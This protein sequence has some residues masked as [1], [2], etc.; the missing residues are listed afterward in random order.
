MRASLTAQNVLWLLTIWSFIYVYQ[1]WAQTFHPSLVLSSRAMSSQTSS[2]SIFSRAQTLEVKEDQVMFH[3]YRN[4]RSRKDYRKPSTK[5]M[6]S[7]FNE[8]QR[9]GNIRTRTSAAN[10]TDVVRSFSGTSS[11]S[12]KTSRTITEF[13]IPYLP[14]HERLK[15]AEIRFLREPKAKP[16]LQQIKIRINIKKGSKALKKIVIRERPQT[17]KE[18]D[19]IDVTNFISPWINS[20]HGNFSLAIRI[21]G[22]QVSQTKNSS[23]NLAQSLIVLYLQDGEFLANM[24]SSFTDSA[25]TARRLSRRKRSSSS[26]LGGNLSSTIRNKRDRNLKKWNRAGK[27]VNCQLHNFEVDFNTIGWGQWIIHPK[28]YNA[29]FCFGVCPSPVDSKYKP[30]NHAMLQT[31]MRLKRPNVAPAPCCVPTRLNPLSM[32]YYEFNELV[33]RHHEDMIAT[34]CGCR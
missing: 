6:V 34:E 22:R 13:H 2:G 32:M 14:P 18:H 16:K 33:V 11:Q 29:Q 9:V 24:Y 20:F 3:F 25:D 5:F 23:D 19:V 4:G 26:I 17:Q 21:T 15:M 28:K 31:L 1:I 8:I 30:T 7:L 10:M 27:K 12:K